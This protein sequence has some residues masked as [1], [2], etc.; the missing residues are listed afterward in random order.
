[1]N[2]DEL[3]NYLG[4]KLPLLS[5][6]EMAQALLEIKVLLGTRTILIHTQHWALTYGQNAERLENALMGGIALAGTRYR[7]GDD[8]TLEQYASTRALPSVENGASF[9]RDLKAL[10][11]TKVCCLPSKRVMEQNVTTIGL[12]DAFVGGFL[13]SLSDGGVVYREKG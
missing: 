12:G 6:R 11:G 5:A 7:F 9:A 2:E 8:F 3:Q 10:L 4:R 1:M 13:S